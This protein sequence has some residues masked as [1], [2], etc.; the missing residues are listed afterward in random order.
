MDGIKIYDVCMVFS[1][2]ATNDD[3]AR[4]MVAETLPRNREDMAW[5]WIYT[6][7]I[8]KGETDE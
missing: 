1:V 6:T 4:S 8:N 2:Y 3:E 7:Q 5:S